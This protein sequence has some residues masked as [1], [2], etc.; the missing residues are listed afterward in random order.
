MSA[1][2]RG[3]GGGRGARR[4]AYTIKWFDLRVGAVEGGGQRD[5][6]HDGDK[7]GNG[8]WGIARWGGGGG[9]CDQKLKH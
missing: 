2:G 8:D 6:A 3:R 7:D 4:R 1:T 5:N 9:D